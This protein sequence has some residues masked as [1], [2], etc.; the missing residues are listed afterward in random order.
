MLDP[1]KLLIRKKKWLCAA[2]GEPLKHKCPE[3]QPP[4]C[5]KFAFGNRFG[6]FGWNSISLETGAWISVPST[7]VPENLQKHFFRPGSRGD[8]KWFKELFFLENSD[9][10]I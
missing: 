7:F 1:G 9:Q 2:K 10:T 8:G 3:V 4:S 5:E 6:L